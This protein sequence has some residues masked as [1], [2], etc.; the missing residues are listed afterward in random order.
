M[1]LGEGSSRSNLESRTFLVEI[2]GSA[3]KTFPESIRKS[4]HKKTPKD[5]NP[6]ELKIPKSIA[7][8]SR[9]TN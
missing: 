8:L 7:A 1:A 9:S 4:V 6:W 2:G 5:K 3:R